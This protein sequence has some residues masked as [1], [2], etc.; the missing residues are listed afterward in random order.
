MGKRAVFYVDGFNLY[1]SINDLG[2]PHLKWFSIYSYAEFVT[3]SAGEALERVRYFSALATHRAP[4]SVNRHRSYL[5]A[6]KRTGVEYVLGQ[7]KNKPR[8]CFNCNSHWIAHEE[9]ETDVNIAV[10][11]IEDAIDQLMEVCYIV[12]ADTDLAPA[13]RLVKRKFSHIEYVCV[14]P[15][16]RRH[17]SE[18]LAIADRKMQ[19]SRNALELNRLPN[20]I[21]DAAGKLVCPPE[22]MPPAK[23]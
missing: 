9:K 5:R 11:M 7:F 18:L 16:G 6:L 10:Q 2:S 4:D 12:S 21:S 19:I 17:P 14:A 23:P 22:W 8:S 20:Q 15:P 3:A 13:I 1:H